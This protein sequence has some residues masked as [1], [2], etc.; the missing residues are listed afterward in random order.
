MYLSE[1]GVFRYDVFTE[2]LV[3]IARQHGL[4]SKERPRGDGVFRNP[5]SL[6]IQTSTLADPNESYA[7]N[8][9]RLTIPKD[10]DPGRNVYY[11]GGP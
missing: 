2:I 11:G 7:V 8:Y 3:A 10:C 4:G 1:G 9:R 5:D 6:R